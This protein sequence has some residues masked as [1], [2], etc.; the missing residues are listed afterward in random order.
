MERHEQAR[1]IREQQEQAYQASLRADQEKEEKARQE[2][3]RQ[4]REQEEEDRQLRLK[5]EKIEA[6]K[7]RR[8]QLRENLAAE[9]DAGEPDLVKI[10]AR[11]PGGDRVMRRFRAGDSVQTLYDFLESLELAPIPPE[12]DVVVVT[13]YP[14]RAL[15]ERGLTLRDCGLFPSA[16]V[17]VE[18]ADEEEDGV[19]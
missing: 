5:A 7:R 14:R 16:T 4:Q 18:E 3:E 15:T 2:R 9:P 6:K 8:Q 10:S 11:L 17:A 1:Q 13:S 12:A 19:D